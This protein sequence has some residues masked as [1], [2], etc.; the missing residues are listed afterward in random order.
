LELTSVLPSFFAGQQVHFWSSQ[1][2]EVGDRDDRRIVL[3]PPILAWTTW[4]PVQWLEGHV[5]VVQM[6]EMG[7]V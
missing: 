6:A 7:W 4:H 3:R 5:G 1:D 2:R